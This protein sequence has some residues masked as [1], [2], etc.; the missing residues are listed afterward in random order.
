MAE[1]QKTSNGFIE[2]QGNEKV[3]RQDFV[4]NINTLDSILGENVKEAQID[5]YKGA[6]NIKS[7][8][9]YISEKIKNNDKI[10]ALI[11]AH[12]KLLKVIKDLRD[13]DNDITATISEYKASVD[14]YSTQ[15]GIYVDGHEQANNKLNKLLNG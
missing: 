14:E 4:D 9:E 7:F 3:Q 13:A 5:G 6:K 12:K 11:N 8:L 10:N 2:F 1:R 15:L